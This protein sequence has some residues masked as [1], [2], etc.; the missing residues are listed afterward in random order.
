MPEQNTTD[1]IVNLIAKSGLPVYSLNVFSHGC[2]CTPAHPFILL[3]HGTEGPVQWHRKEKLLLQENFSVAV[4][5]MDIR[6]QGLGLPGLRQH[7]ARN[8]IEKPCGHGCRMVVLRLIKDDNFFTFSN[9]L[10]CQAR[11]CQALAYNDVVN[12][13]LDLENQ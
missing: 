8:R 5:R 3:F 6:K 9:E 1:G 11:A 7:F 13:H 2:V 12:F 10:Q 4:K